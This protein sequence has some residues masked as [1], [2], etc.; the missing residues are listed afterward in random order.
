MY[1]NPWISNYLSHVKFCS[2]GLG[3][4]TPIKLGNTRLL[5]KRALSF[6]KEFSFDEKDQPAKSTKDI[7][8]NL[9][10]N[11]PKVSELRKRFEGITTSASDFEMNRKERIARRLEGIEGEVHPSLLPS[12]VANRL[13]EEDTPRYTRAS[14][15]CEPCGVQRYGTESLESPEMQ[16]SAPEQHSRP[17]CRDETQSSI[18]TEPVYSLGSTTS[19]P[20]L[21]SRAERIA[22]YKAERRRQLAERYGISLDQEAD[23]DYSSRYARSQT[24]SSERRSRGELVGEEGGSSTLSAYTNTSATN[25]RAG[26]WMPPHSHPDTGGEQGRSRVDSFSEREMLM[27]LENQHRAQQ[28]KAFPPQPPSSS[29]YMDVTAF[30][31]S[32][33]VPVRDNPATG[34]PPGSPT[35]SRHLSLSSPKRGVSPGDLFIEQQAHNILSRQGIKVRE[36]LAREEGR[37]RSP[38]LENVTEAPV[39]SRQTY[40]RYHTDPL[41]SKMAYSHP[42]PHHQ[43]QLT[44]FRPTGGEEAGG[45]PSYLSMMSG[46][47]SR[48][49]QQQWS[50]EEE[51]EES[52]D[53]KTEGLLKSRKAVLPSEIR[54]RE[55]STE[56][57]WRGRGEEEAGT[58]RAQNLGQVREV[59]AEEPTRERH[60]GRARHS[61]ED[62]AD[63]H[64]HSRQ[65]AREWESAIYI[66]RGVAPTHL[67]PKV[68][69]A[70]V[71]G[72]S[73][74]AL[75]CSE[76]EDP[77]GTNQ[78]SLQRTR[79]RE[80]E[81]A[82]T[83][84]VG[85]SNGGSHQDARISVAQLRH[86]YME[87]TT[88]SRRPEI[89]VG[90]EGE[91]VSFEAPWRGA[92]D[93]GRKPRQYI[94]PGESRKTSE[95]FRTQPVTSAERQETDRSCVSSEFA[96]AEADEEKLDERAK[97]SVAAKRSLFRELE[98]SF[99]GG[100][101][102]PRSRNAAVD[103]RLRRTQDRSR[104]QPV[105]TEEV[106]IAATL[107]ASQQGAA[108]SGQVHEARHMHDAQ[109]PRRSRQVA[110]ADAKDEKQ[111][112]QEEPDLCTLSLAEKMALFNRLAQPPTRVTRTR[113]D[114]RQRRANARYQT[115]PI[116]LGDMEQVGYDH[117][118]YTQQ[119]N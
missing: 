61:R 46:P 86:T 104:T 70:V 16:L 5:Q 74:A 82:P 14:D 97:L 31:S 69:R 24:S 93:R 28:E 73:S 2:Q 47:T 60:R 88:S 91:L 48:S 89:E 85:F 39:C 79:A 119:N 18:H 41:R 64:R 29:S 13:L 112:S 77:Q 99:D 38:D 9:L 76:S 68:A 34:V 11:L 3:S 84:K 51:C 114:T 12:L 50:Q 117:M 4:E 106:V 101:P 66:H 17:R 81:G 62:T 58:S 27:N 43:P 54:R 67:Q 53:V 6:Q 105:T 30:S 26:R 21:E 83:Y 45:H 33:R 1:R 10:A 90:E 57:P 65:K 25:P 108:A 100:V 49:L 75:T 95:R 92:R 35:L 44:R 32:A 59:E 37:Q 98:K 55:R 22:R 56:D 103:R 19:A 96:S 80:G 20:E 42:Q 40:A 7:D 113:E 115:Q 15:P 102:K 23:T 94:R 110:A 118:M 63:P 36:K 107:Q 111:T 78:R 87:S 71:S 109:D 52:V 72:S 116:T 8:V